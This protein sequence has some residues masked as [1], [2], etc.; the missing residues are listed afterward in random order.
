MKKELKKCV[1]ELNGLPPARELEG[2]FW[3]AL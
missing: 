2:L 3:V 1:Y